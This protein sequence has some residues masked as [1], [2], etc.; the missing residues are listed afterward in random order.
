ME[1]PQLV[2]CF[3]VHTRRGGPGALFEC[4]CVDTSVPVRKQD[5]G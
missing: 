2:I 3:A 1:A 5:L 4:V